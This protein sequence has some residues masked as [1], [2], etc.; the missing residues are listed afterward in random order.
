MQRRI[1]YW[2][3]DNLLQ[4]SHLKT[5][6][7]T[8]LLI[9]TCAQAQVKSTCDDNCTF[10]LK[11]SN[12]SELVVANHER[13]EKRFSPFSTFKIPNSLIALEL[14]VVSS[15]DQKLTFDGERYP[16]EGWWR[17]SWYES[18][19]TLKQAFELS[20]VPIYRQIAY[21][22]GEK[23]MNKLLT[24]FD[25]GNKDINSGIDNFWL[26]G[27]IR[28]SAK[29]QV[30]FLQRLNEGHLPVS[31]QALNQFK[32]VMEAEKADSYVLYAKT[33]A[34][35]ISNERVLGWYVGFVETKG[36]VHYFAFNLE[37]ESFAQMGKKR[38][39]KARQFLTEA[40]VI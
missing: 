3:F 36:E 7:F 15:L 13:S 6:L 37:D 10:V 33:G 40:G 38:I 25:Y 24:A 39:A 11:K 27:S 29:E 30:A 2:F 28:I 4:G 12:G 26:N 18:P 35:R 20:A 8:L 16:V 17:K 14:D 19:L 32:T 31:K 9:S 22:V 5:L 1:V 21:Q 23:Q 34:G